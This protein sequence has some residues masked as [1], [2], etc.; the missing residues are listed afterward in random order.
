MDVILKFDR[1]NYEKHGTCGIN[2][3]NGI[4]VL[5]EHCKIFKIEETKYGYQKAVVELGQPDSLDLMKLWETRVNEYLKGEGIPPKT[6][7]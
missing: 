5:K 4:L 2:I 1:V 3:E 6:I 7:I